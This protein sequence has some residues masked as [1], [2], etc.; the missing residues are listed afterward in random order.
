MAERAVLV[1]QLHLRRDESAHHVRP[2][3][4]PQRPIDATAGAAPSRNR[5]SSTVSAGLPLRTV[6]AG[7]A[8][9]EPPAR[10][11]PRVDQSAKRPSHLL[12]RRNDGA[13]CVGPSSRSRLKPRDLRFC[14]VLTFSHVRPENDA[15]VPKQRYSRSLGP[16][17]EL[18]HQAPAP[19]FVRSGPQSLFVSRCPSVVLVSTAVKGG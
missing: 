19:E 2:R 9:R 1:R 7:G 8:G 18:L 4:P 12:G 5:S 3:H 10:E 15:E 17:Q 16:P 13:D 11:A 14:R 6:L